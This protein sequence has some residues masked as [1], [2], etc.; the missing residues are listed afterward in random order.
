[1]GYQFASQG[2]SFAVA[3]RRDFVDELEEEFGL[4]VSDGGDLPFVTI[5]T[6]QGF[7]YTMREEFT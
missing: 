4:G 1:M 6:R 3:N 2:L 7:K 5:R